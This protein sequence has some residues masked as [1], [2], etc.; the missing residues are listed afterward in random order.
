MNCFEYLLPGNVRAVSVGGAAVRKTA[1]A[2][3]L[4]LLPAATSVAAT[5]DVEFDVA[6]LVAAD[7]VT[8]DAFRAARPGEKLVAVR[9]ELSSLVRR[10]DAAD[11]TDVLYR[12]E[13]LDHDTFVIDYAP[14]TTFAPLANGAV[15]VER[16][17]GEKASINASVK[18]RY[19]PLAEADAGYTK[20]VDEQTRLR[21]E[22]P[23]PHEVVVTSGS[24]Q[25]RHGVFVKLR[26]SRRGSLEGAKAVVITFAV[27]QNWRGGLM[28]I[29]AEARSATGG[30]LGGGDSIVC[31]KASYLAGVYLTGDLK[32]RDAVEVLISAEKAWAQAQAD[33][34]RRQNKGIG[35]QVS[36]A[37]DELFAFSAA[38]K[39]RDRATKQNAADAALHDAKS[40]REDAASVLAKM[41]AQ[42]R[43]DIAAQALPRSS[44]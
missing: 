26:A 35:E 42:P 22:M 32:V 37:V 1:L 6:S 23:T 41:N 43:A 24:W 10:G 36:V 40:T 9:M 19:L 29:E 30:V 16:D 34:Q 13:G 39:R 7:D 8:T 18:G 12:V 4:A 31:G 38:K 17:S 15:A 2:M 3:V 27:P 14:K 44:E 5:P 21:Y 25:R 11:L 20:N 28:R 33:Q